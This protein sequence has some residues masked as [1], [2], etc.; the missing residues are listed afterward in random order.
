MEKEIIEHNKARSI[1]LDTGYMY[2]ESVKDPV[3]DKYVGFI[4]MVKESDNSFSY[5]NFNMETKMGTF[6]IE[7]DSIFVEPFRNLVA[8]DD[9]FRI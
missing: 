9:E 6:Y 1:T 4:S 5:I 3:T 2:Q 8:D 7:E